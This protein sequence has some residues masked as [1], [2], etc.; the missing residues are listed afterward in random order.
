MTD[1]DSNTY[2][3][4]KIGDQWWM[5]ENLKVTR[6]SNGDTI[7]NVTDNAEWAGLSTGALCVYSND[8]G[9]VATYGRLYNWYAVDDNRDLAPTGWHVPTDDEW[10]ELEIYLGMSQTD[11]DSTEWRGTVEGGKLKLTGTTY[12]NS[13]NTGATNESGF[14]TLPGGACSSSN[15]NFYYRGSCA[16]YWSSVEYDRGTAWHRRL[17]NSSSGVY[18]HIDTKRLGFSVRCIWDSISLTTLQIDPPLKTIDIGDTLQFFCTASY[19]DSTTE[20]ITTATWSLSPGIAG[21]INGSGQFIAHDTNTGTETIIAAY[22]GHSDTATVNVVEMGSVTDI[23]D[24]TYHTVKIGDQ[25]WMAEN[26]RVTHY[27]NGDTI[28]NVTDSLEW[29]NLSTGALC[30]YSNDEGLVATYGRLYNWY[31]VNDTGQIAPAGWHVPIDDDWQML[32]DFLGGDAVA[33]LKLKEAGTS[34]WLGSNPYA[35]NETGFTALPAGFRYSWGVFDDLRAYNANWSATEY[36]GSDAWSWN[37]DG[38]W[39]NIHHYNYN[40]LDGLSIRC[41]KD[42]GLTVVIPNGDETWQGG[43]N[44]DIIWTSNGTSETVKIE[45]STNNGS[46]WNLAINSTGDDDTHT[47]TVPNDKSTQCLIRISDTDGSPSDQ[48]DSVFTIG[49]TVP[50][51]PVSSTGVSYPVVIENCTIDGKVIQPGDVIGVFDNNLCV[52][53]GFFTGNFPIAI[54]TFGE[55]SPPI[56]P[57]LPGFRIGYPLFF[58]IWQQSTCTV[59]SAM[60]TYISGSG[61]FGETLTVVDLLEAFTTVIQE[62]ILSPGKLNMISLNV[63]PLNP[64]AEDVFHDL[65]TLLVVQNDAGNFYIP[66]YG[67]NTIGNVETCKGYQ[68]YYTSAGPETLYVEGYPIQPEECNKNITNTKLYMI[69]CTYQ[70]PHPIL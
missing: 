13:P 28:P 8:E 29:S 7:P 36:N 62:I 61:F 3:T 53:M 39:P 37:M 23:D 70:L 5:A 52:G 27:S 10:K 55:Y 65:S 51:N 22:Q 17:N 35:T 68:V 56:G 46:I 25:W 33:G 34:H 19:S 41:V 67:V 1:I 63:N 60:P 49:C 32:V 9:L 11:A 16:F 66:P 38:A 24:N 47:W 59:F 58:K 14:S 26:L 12:W 43:S 4:V 31:A 20:G 54:S 21:S 30:T 44:H 50:F 48:S 18:R 69:C 6:Y 42:D 15:G 64:L 2:Q 45:Y 57:V 40:K